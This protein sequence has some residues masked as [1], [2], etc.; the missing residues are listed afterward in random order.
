MPSF[1]T[2]IFI[3]R[4]DLRLQDNSGLNAALRCSKNVMP[5]FIF[6]PRQIGEHAY[7]SKPGLQFMLQCL[8]DL[9]QQLA[10]AGGRLALYRGRPEDIIRQLAARQRIDAVFVN[11][12]YTPFSHERDAQIAD[13][14]RQL[15]IA[16]HSVPDA[17]LLEPE[18]GLKS[19]GTPY[20]VFSAFYNRAR[21]C[22]VALPESLQAGRLAQ[23]AGDFALDRLNGEQGRMPEVIP[24]GR[25]QALAMLEKLQHLSAYEQQRDYPC[26]EA[27]SRL[28]AHLKFGSCSV[29]EAYYAV[30][31]QLGAEHALLR[32]LYWRD[33]FTH[34]ALHFPA[35][36]GHA[37]VQ[38]F[39]QLPWDNHPDLFQAW[40]AGN[41]GF[42]IVDAGMRE[43]NATGFM[44]NRVRMISASFL[45][46]DLHIDWRWGERYFAR[47]LVDYDPCVNNG[48]WQWAASTGCD[49][50]P[51]FRIFNPW[52]QQQKF[53]PECRYIY[54][55]LAE[56][57]KF[58]PA[59]IHHWDKKYTAG[60]YPAPLIDHAH[61]SGIA[62]QRYKAAAQQH[63]VFSQEPEPYE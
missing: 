44:H 34:I 25:R 2:S 45:V 4:R 38:K 16:L 43:L 32:Q 61:A 14:C 10:D 41:T 23:Q 54:R 7:Q 57:R 26:Q 21:Q 22:P 30:V 9:E 56:L 13:V 31:A 52:S 59:V 11:R 5:C 48:N 37:F 3:F 42:P 47:H 12:D 15:G 40:C 19:D 36:F 63:R 8:G 55:W 27:T 51:Y 6:D 18:Q 1:D 60:E 24:G 20:K 17:L 50:Q 49:A 35:V 28:S 29:R 39:E 46:K 62:K 58:P 53:D 33:F